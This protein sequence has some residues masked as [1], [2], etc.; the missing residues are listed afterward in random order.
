MEQTKLKES[1]TIVISKVNGLKFR[2]DFPEETGKYW[3]EL[4]RS[5]FTVKFLFETQNILKVDLGKWTNKEK[6]EFLSNS[7]SSVLAQ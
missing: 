3:A 4:I 6:I 5:D 7:Y 2:E 1:L